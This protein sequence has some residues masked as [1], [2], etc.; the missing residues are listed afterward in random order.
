MGAD[1]GIWHIVGLTLLQA[2]LYSS[3]VVMLTNTQ[4]F[5][6]KP[7]SLTVQSKTKIGGKRL[8]LN[9]SKKLDLHF[10]LNQFFLLKS[11][12]TKKITYTSQL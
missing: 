3:P 8:S 2:A 9:V 5:P 1:I 7:G 12:S 10:I 11:M 4:R 6:S